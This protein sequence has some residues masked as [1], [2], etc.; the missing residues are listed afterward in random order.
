MVR[1]SGG[2]PDFFLLVLVAVEAT[3][4]LL[5]TARISEG[6][7]V[8]IYP[9]STPSA[10]KRLAWLPS[11]QAA[12]HA[13]FV[14]LREID[15]NGAPLIMPNSGAQKISDKGKQRNWLTLLVRE[16]L[17]IITTYAPLIIITELIWTVAIK[18]VLSTQIVRVQYEGRV[19]FFSVV[20]VSEATQGR[21]NQASDV[22]D[23]LGALNISDVPSLCIVD[24]DT[25][26]T[27]EDIV[28]ASEPKPSLV[29][30]LLPSMSRHL[31]G[32]SA[33][34]RRFRTTNEF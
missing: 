9:L 1:T 25:T 8:V 3:A 6:S 23:S 30:G 2:Q 14:Q 34:H 5:L 31:T 27:I 28:R 32:I 7:K 29:M 26:I 15:A 10:T 11:L 4:T 12:Q 24:W 19:R 22:S 18:H 13:S 16:S 20:S 17:G 33:R 21:R